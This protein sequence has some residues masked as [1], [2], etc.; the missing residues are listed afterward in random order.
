MKYIP[1]KE[2]DTRYPLW[3]VLYECRVPWHQMRTIEEIEMFGTPSNGTRERDMDMLNENRDISIPIVRMAELYGQGATVFLVHQNKTKEIYEVISD[4]LKAWKTRLEW[5]FNAGDVPIDDLQLL[6][7]FANSVY[8][9]A[10]YQLSDGY[11]QGLFS[12][13]HSQHGVNRNDIRRKYFKTKEQRDPT[14]EASPHP[15]RKGLS[16]FFAPFKI[17]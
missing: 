5:Q 6:D 11:V 15:K 13:H 8:E 14:L 12:R 10:K 1:P 16:E 17:N 4:H 9:H 7:R 3:Y 2:R